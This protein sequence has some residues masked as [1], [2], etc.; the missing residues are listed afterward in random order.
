MHHLRHRRLAVAA[1][2]LLS[3]PLA[4]VAEAPAARA[5]QWDPVSGEVTQAPPA[6]DDA[7][8]PTPPAPT[9]K[10]WRTPPR[11]VVH[12][13]EFLANG[14]TGRL[15]E[16]EDAVDDVVDQFNEVGRT[17]A[18]V[19]SW[20]T[21]DAPFDWFATFTDP[22]PTIHVG[23]VDGWDELLAQLGL[24]PDGGIEVPDLDAQCR[25]EGARI[26]FPTPDARPQDY[27]TPFD[28]GGEGFY[29][30]G[31]TNA[32]G[33]AW[34]RPRFQHELLHAFGLEHS[35]DTYS[36]LNFR[37]LPWA[38]RSSSD[39]IR[40]LPADVR[41]LREWYPETGETRWDVAVLT[42]WFD[43]FA[44]E[45][46]T[47]E[48]PA[49]QEVVCAPSG[50]I[51]HNPVDR[52]DLTCGAG[53][54]DGGSNVLCA[55]DTLFTRYALANYGSRHMDVV[56]GL[57]LSLDETWDLGDL[58]VDWAPGFQVQPAHS[59]M[60]A[61]TWTLPELEPGQTYHP[62]VKVIAL[63]VNDDPNS[64]RTDWSPL[65]GTIEGCSPYA[66]FLSDEPSAPPPPVEVD[67]FGGPAATPPTKP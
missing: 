37:D 58:V 26:A 65:P 49:L 52:A 28:G 51:A 40:P 36:F 8:P 9:C 14:G 12:E 53:G 29:E 67:P 46:G 34:F 22:V 56:T 64:V 43:S 54:A 30:T 7:G 5:E 18:E 2:A 45:P 25:T 10:T 4:L 66:S 33:E 24:N 44:Q 17:T 41:L 62:I 11:V 20:S 38:N 6:D 15:S 35:N 50:G 3:L 63:A 31:E 13:T 42:T 55:G 21:T 39:A 61:Q 19:T 32:Y 47:V 59:S 16:L 23:F 1:S 27:G 57:Y 60:R 48:P